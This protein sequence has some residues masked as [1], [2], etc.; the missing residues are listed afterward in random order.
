MKPRVLFVNNVVYLPGEGGYKR[1]LYLFDMM[2]AAGYP[3][4]LMTSNFNHYSKNVRDLERFRSEHPDV[5]DIRF[6]TVPPYKKNISL[7]RYYSEW[8]WKNK[9]KK[10]LTDNI[11][12]YD[13]IYMNMPDYEQINSVKGLCHKRGK[14]II[15]DIRDLR[16]E[17]FHVMV[18]N[19]TL[20]KILFYWMRVA[21][22]K[23]YACADELVAV[24][25]EYLDI[26]LRVNKKSKHPT[27]VYIGSILDKFYDG[28]KKYSGSINKGQ[29][30]FW[31]IY[32]GT[33]GESYDLETVILA[34]KLVKEKGL[35]NYRLKILGQGPSEEH[36]KNYAASIQAD[37][38]DFVGFVDYERMAAYLSKSDVTINAI[39]KNAS[40][41]IINKVAD[42]FA[43]GKPMLNSCCCQEQLDMVTEYNVGYNYEPG[44]AENLADYI[45]EIA[46]NPGKRETMGDNAK[47]LATKLFDRRNS[48]KK[49][50][51]LI[52]SV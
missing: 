1:T 34:S 32:A 17:A 52:E 45:F 7:K 26:A 2:R 44:N 24:S 41:S 10:W 5:G 49:I 21:A 42:Y 23:A 39:K 27:V 40:Q 43:A 19:D 16:P 4:T 33:L 37:N 31:G 25:K 12:D 11:D 38:V 47:A 3:V 28:I 46:A 13:V 29:D 8:V 22:D 51:E 9:F 14:K 36:L 18:K 48:Y 30:E 6:L 20:F 15:L 35:T 50:I